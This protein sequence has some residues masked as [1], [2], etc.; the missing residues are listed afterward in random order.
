MENN[1]DDKYYIEKMKVHFERILETISEVSY[2][3]Y[4][5]D[6]DKQDITMFNLIQIS[7]N[8]KNISSEYKD[9]NLEI[10]WNDIYGL[11]NRI[12]HDYGNVILDTVYKTLIEDIPDLYKKLYK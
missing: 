5:N 4:I 11:R 12:V 1:K 9:N 8:A 2:E 6:L 7:E 3:N 10:P